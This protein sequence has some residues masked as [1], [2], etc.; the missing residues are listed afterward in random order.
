MGYGVLRY[1]SEEAGVREQMRRIP[2]G[3][4][5]FNYLGR[6]DH[7]AGDDA[8]V[9]LSDEPA[10]PLQSE[11]GTRRYLL[12]VD[13]MVTGG[14]LEMSWTYSEDVHWRVTVERLAEEYIKS[15]REIIAHCES[16]GAQG[17]TPSDFPEAN[18]SQAELDFLISSISQNQ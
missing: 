5:S 1:L 6:F 2:R 15:L 8:P 4:L 16:A 18:L 9:Q 17:F 12:T 11:R 7:V 10:G 3:E 13:S 14:K